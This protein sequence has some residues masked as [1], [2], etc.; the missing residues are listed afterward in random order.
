MS[1]KVFN[2]K[3]FLITVVSKPTCAYL[4]YSTD[5]QLSPTKLVMDLGFLEEKQ[6]RDV[7][8]IAIFVVSSLMF[9]NKTYVKD[10]FQVVNG[11]RTCADNS[12]AKNDSAYEFLQLIKQE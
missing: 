4:D 6:C 9:D 11:K 2:A 3:F 5:Y 8:L 1:I 7:M 12:C 10:S